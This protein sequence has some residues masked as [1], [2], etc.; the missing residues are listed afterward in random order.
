MVIKQEE[1]EDEPAGNAGLNRPMPSEFISRFAL[2]NVSGT[3]AIKPGTDY[4]DY[5]LPIPGLAEASRGMTVVEFSPDSDGVYRRTRPVRAYGGSYFPVLGLAPF[6]NDSS[7]VAFR[8]GSIVINDR[9]V[10]VAHPLRG[11]RAPAT[12]PLVYSAT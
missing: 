9:V 6:I 3:P 5:V 1:P 10:P 11:L 12:P 2:R 7:V 8:E 4:N